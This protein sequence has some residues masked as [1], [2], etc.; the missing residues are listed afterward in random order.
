MVTFP[1]D[2]SIETKS[3]LKNEYEV[4]ISGRICANHYPN[5]ELNLVLVLLEERGLSIGYGASFHFYLKKLYQILHISKSK[6]QEEL[7][8]DFLSWELVKL[9]LHRSYM[10]QA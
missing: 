4:K 10:Y 9:I 5:P 1:L 2:F 6:T 3:W 7:P 8:H